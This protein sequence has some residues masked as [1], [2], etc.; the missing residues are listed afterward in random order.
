MSLV[1]AGVVAALVLAASLFPL[2][3]DEEPP[4]AVV[5]EAARKHA[6]LLARKAML[7]EAIQDLDFDHATGKLTKADYDDVRKG[8][9][10]Q[11]AAVIKSL[12]A[13]DLHDDLDRTIERLVTARRS[14]SR[15]DAAGQGS[16]A[17][18]GCGA[19]VAA[20][21][22]FCTSCGEEAQPIANC[23]RCGQ[24]FREGDRFCGACGGARA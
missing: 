12:E 13:I 17:C 16:R 20:G 2:W 1:A 24:T 8:L 4:P 10:G 15:P 3:R 9:V 18:A 5:S 7:Y 11:A 19:G 21:S 23:T 14:G 22:R 6:Q